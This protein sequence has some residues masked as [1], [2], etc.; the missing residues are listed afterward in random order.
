MQKS[1]GA[2]SKT[3]RIL[4][5]DDHKILRTGLRELLEK[6]PHLKV[7]AEAEDG[8]TAVQLCRT[9]SPDVV[10]MDIS[11]QDLNGVEATRQIM[12]NSPQTKV[13]VLSMHSGQKFVTEVLK[14]GA[15]GYLLKDCDFSEMFTAIR[16]VMANETYLCPQ[17]ATILRNDYVQRLSQTAGPVAP[18]LSPR[19]REVLQLMAEGK[20]TKEIA[21]AFHL[22][23]KTVEVHR[24]RIME[25]L[26][27]HNIA[28][29]T[30]YAIREGLTSLDS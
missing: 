5:A 13:I 2:G 30:K 4:L 26:N 10:I 15:S 24:Q 27:I 12:E 9:L 18:A 19:E 8:R 20:S 21:Y 3:I 23:V 14:A 25:K 28:E 7:V 6:E 29:L 16:A 17:I 22:S 1:D 11:M